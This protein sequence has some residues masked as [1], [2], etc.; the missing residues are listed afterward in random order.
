MNCERFK[1]ERLLHEPESIGRWVTRP[2]AS[3]ASHP[4]LNW[5]QSLIK[6]LR[7]RKPMFGNRRRFKALL[8]FLRVKCSLTS[9]RHEWQGSLRNVV[10]H[11]LTAYNFYDAVLNNIFGFIGMTNQETFAYLITLMHN[12]LV[13]R[14]TLQIQ[15]F[16]LFTYTITLK[17]FFY[18]IKQQTR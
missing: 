7:L 6:E 1:D 9:Y 16:L 15:P 12:R 5:P 14:I 4:L 8:K 3:M 13:L 2:R 17:G 18:V 10:N 11:L